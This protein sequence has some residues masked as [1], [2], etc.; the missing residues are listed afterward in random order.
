[1][2]KFLIVI[3]IVILILLMLSGIVVY[4]F[5]GHSAVLTT[6]TDN[7]QTAVSG[8][9]DVQKLTTEIGEKGWIVYCARS[10]NETWDIYAS[11]PDGSCARNITNTPD[12]EEAGPMFSRDNQQ[13]LFRRLEKGTT[14]NHDLWG[15]QGQLMIADADGSNA[16]PLGNDKEYAWA[17]WSPDGKS[18]LCLTRK[19]IQVIDLVTREIKRRLPR[20]GIYQQL[21]WS[22]DGK[23][24][25]GTGNISGKQW[26][27]VRMNAESGQINP[28]ITFQSCTPDWGPD[29]NQI[30]FSSRPA[31]QSTSNSYGWSQL[32]IADGEGKQIDLVYGE[33]DFH[34]Y[35]GTLSPGSAY[36]LFTKCA[37]DGGGSEESGAPM[38]IMRM[39]DSPVITGESPYL[40]EHFPNAK[41]APVL[42]LSNGWEPIWTYAEVFSEK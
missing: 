19:D 6:H 28:I 11:R 10:D 37:A 9:G 41:Q 25:T 32:Y 12:Y 42:T 2:G 8:D 29:P 4:L 1:M 31:N 22:P 21:F 7:S 39:S 33:D 5:F 26:C 14:I 34:I 23:W 20:N 36:V 13:L 40:Q 24:F 38:C 35:G 17:S 27:V 30:I 16:K 18:I 3:L 15:F